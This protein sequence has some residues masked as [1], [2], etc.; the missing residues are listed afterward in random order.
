MAFDGEGH[1]TIARTDRPRIRKNRKNQ[2]LDTAVRFSIVMA[3]TN[4]DA[5]LMVWL[6][7]YFG[8]KAYYN[9]KSKNPNSKPKHRWHVMGRE[10]QERI[11]LG[12]LPYLVLKREQALIALEFIRMNSEINPLKRQELYERM[13]PLNRRGK[14]VETNTT[15]S[16]EPVTEMIESDLV[17]DYESAPAVTQMA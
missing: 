4:T 14:L 8:G 7:K 15:D 3:V 9:N 11:L 2:A 12:I 1:I 17:G 6:E 5:R 16:V 10:H 13:K